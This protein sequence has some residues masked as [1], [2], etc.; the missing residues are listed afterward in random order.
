MLPRTLKMTNS[1]K[2]FRESG[3]SRFANSYLELKNSHLS[4][5]S[6]TAKERYLKLIKEHPE[7]INNAS[8]K[9]IATY[10]VANT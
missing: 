6:T 5:I 9:H 2:G 8:L 1:I 4:I 7:I 10:S 3:R